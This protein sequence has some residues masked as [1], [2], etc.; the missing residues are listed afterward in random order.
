MDLKRIVVA[1]GMG[2]LV[3]TTAVGCIIPVP[4][5]HYHH[6]HHYHHYRRYDRAWES[7]RAQPTPPPVTDAPVTVQ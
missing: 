1:V 3:A 6:Y 2:C 5:Y 4:V 7:Q